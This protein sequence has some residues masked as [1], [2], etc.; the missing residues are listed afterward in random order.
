MLELCDRKLQKGGDVKDNLKFGW[1]DASTVVMLAA[2]QV[3][4]ACILF[5]QF[6]VKHAVVQWCCW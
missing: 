5:S 2:S 4:V 6:F 1:M 3:S